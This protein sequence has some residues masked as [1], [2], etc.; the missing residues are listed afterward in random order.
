M[1]ERIGKGINVDVSRLEGG[2]PEKVLYDPAQ[3][4]AVKAAG[5]QSIRFFVGAG[6]DPAIYKTRIQD[7]F[8]R[9][10]AVV[11][12]L[13]GSGQWAS[14]PKEGIQEF[15]AIWD[16]IAKY[17][18]DYPGSLV[19]EFWN[20]PA[21]L[22]VEPGGIQGI[23]DGKTV[24]EY[25]NAAIPIIRTTNPDRTLG[26]GG[27]GFNGGRELEEFVTPEYLTYRLED[28]SGFVAD[29]C[30][31]HNIGWIYYCA[32]FNNQ[33]AFNIL[34]TED[35]WNQDALD[36]LT[37]VTA[38]PPPPM[39]PLI[40]SEFSSGTDHWTGEGSVQTSVTRSAGLSGL[41]ALKVE[42][43][44]S[45]RAEIYQETPKREWNPPGRYLISLRKGRLY[46][47]SFLAKSV[48]GMGTLKVRLADVSGSSDGFWTST[49]VTISNAKREYTIEYKH[50]G[51]DIRDVRVA[52]LFGDR[53]QV[54]LLD[55]I[56]LH[57]FPNVP[58]GFQ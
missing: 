51:G 8:D 47:I 15:V 7:A 28:G 49:P 20:E 17:Y 18:K 37:E 35:G 9:D 39:S 55:R 12:C 33:W 4:D 44:K 30:K 27:P 50:T 41:A 40:N 52:F 5:F 46:K 45:D 53:D 29:E 19:F 3:Y 36:I 14:K 42:I 31:K 25:L 24:M 54:I 56:A 23:K 32:G 58:P 34:N 11:I 13:W 6:E 43:K 26:I 16:R 21:G 48:G 57:G 38:P 2:P 22:I 10:L 1:F